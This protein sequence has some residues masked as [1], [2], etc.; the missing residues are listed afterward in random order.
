MAVLEI[1]DADGSVLW[2]YDQDEAAKCGT[3]DVC[4]PLLENKLAYLVNDILS[5]Q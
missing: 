2:Q 3:L 4:T 1:Q 5:D